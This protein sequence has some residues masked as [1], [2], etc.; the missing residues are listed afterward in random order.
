MSDRAFLAQALALAALGEGRTRPNP[1]VGCVVVRDGVVRG[2]GYHRA[3]GAPHA[4]ALAIDDAGAA[5]R[6]ATLYVNLEPCAHRGRT[7]PCTDAIVR[8]GIARVV[9]SVRDPNPLVDGRGF[10]ALR[11]AGIELT[12]GL[13]EDEARA[14][15]APF[16]STHTR[17]RPSVTLKAAQSWD[18]RIA[19]AEGRS[20]WFS[21]EPARRFAHRLRFTH[22]ATLV[23]AGTVRRDD[24][25]LDVRL[26]GVTAPRLRAVIAPRAGIDPGA[27]VLVPEPDGPRTR[28]YVDAA[29][30]AAELAPIAGVAEVVPV[31]GGAGGL[32]LARVASDL[33]AAGVQSLLV[34]GGG[35]TAGAFLRAGLVDTI[36]LVVAPRLVGALG[37]TPL[38]DL[39]AASSPDRAW[40]FEPAT[41][42]P[43]GRDWIVYGRPSEVPCSPA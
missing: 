24:P 25:R 20:A 37:A 26:P 40:I 22:D 8:A 30:G 2:R 13:L 35:K 32:D 39:P 17:G 42:L 34:E 10:E 4:E 9:A 3:A 15:N 12:V 18:G 7:P 11:R 1:L 36:V 23:G 21:G 28:V 14:L 16:F 33:H 41:V 5:A 31:P 43:L 29:C 19:A 38:L 27:R 6:G